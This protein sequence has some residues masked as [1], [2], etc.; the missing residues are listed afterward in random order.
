MEAT[1]KDDQISILKEILKWIRFT[2]MNQVR[3]VLE[4]ELKTDA[5]KLIYQHSDGKHGTVELG[6]LAGLS[7]AAVHDRWASWTKM[8]LG[9]SIAARGGS[10]FKRSFDLEDFGI[11]VPEAKAEKEQEVKEGGPV[12][13]KPEVAE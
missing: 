2:G 8:G 12:E 11:E 4:T 6:K 9:E 7:N 13:K 10:R 1:A 5:D 3:A